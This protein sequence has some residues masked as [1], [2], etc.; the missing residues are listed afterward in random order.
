MTTV[1]RNSPFAYEDDPL[2]TWFVIRVINKLRSMYL[3]VVFPFASI[4][5]K[6]SFHYTCNIRNPRLIKIGDCVIVMHH[7]W[8]HPVLRKDVDGPTLIIDDRCVIARRSQ[9]VAKNSIHIEHDVML[10]AGVLIMDHDH[11]YE[12]VTLPIKAQGTTPGGTIRIEQGCF[13]GYGAAILCAKGELVLGRNSVVGAN[14]VVT[15][16]VPPYS[17]VSGN[18]VRIVRQFDPVKQVWVM[19]SVRS[20]ETALVK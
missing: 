11:A 6:G 18:P 8:I 9:I 3:S 17:V 20:M 10:A 16:S 2:P 12:D 13:I 4:G 19:G 5:K 1:D 14:A 15:R 7:A